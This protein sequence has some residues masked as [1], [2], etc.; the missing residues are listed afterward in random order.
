MTIRRALKQKLGI[1]ILDE[2]QLDKN[3]LESEDAP[4]NYKKNE[5]F[6]QLHDQSMVQGNTVHID[7]S[8]ISQEVIK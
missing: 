4:L 1:E 8:G 6:Q 3:S 5:N 7:L 2:V